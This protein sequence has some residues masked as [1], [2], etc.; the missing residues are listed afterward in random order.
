M[1]LK[2]F[3]QIAGH[4]AAENAGEHPHIELVVNRLQDSSQDQITDTSGQSRCAVVL[5]RKAHRDAERENQR[6]VGKDRSS[7]VCEPFDVEQVGLSQTEQ[8]SGNRKHRDRQH[9]CST[10]F[11]K[12]SKRSCAHN[13]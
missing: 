13:R 9:Q 7:G 4:D 1:S 3:V 11:L 12:F 10:E 5:L 2:R 6:E 8:K